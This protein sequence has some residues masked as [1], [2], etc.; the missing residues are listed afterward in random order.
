VNKTEFKCIQE[1]DE[2]STSA[3]DYQ[4]YDHRLL[5]QQRE[6]RRYSDNFQSTDSFPHQQYHQTKDSTE[7]QNY[8]E[9]DTIRQADHISN[10]QVKATRE[11]KLNGNIHKHIF[12]D[13][14]MKTKKNYDEI[15]S[16]QQKG[17]KF[18]K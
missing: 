7:A 10:M 6:F 12:N 4:V 16:S 8:T 3:Q 9:N 17:V 18:Q 13:E 15:Y 1:V 14:N 2:S 5:E 11:L